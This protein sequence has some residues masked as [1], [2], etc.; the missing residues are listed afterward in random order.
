MPHHCAGVPNRKPLH[1]CSKG[2]DTLGRDESADQ[3]AK[4]GLGLF[5]RLHSSRLSSLGD[6]GTSPNQ[7]SRAGQR[8][9]SADRLNRSWIRSAQT[10][11]QWSRNQS[12]SRSRSFRPSEAADSP[13]RQPPAQGQRPRH[14]RPDR[15]AACGRPARAASARGYSRTSPAP[16]ASRQA[17]SGGQI[18]GDAG[19]DQ[20]TIEQRPG[21]IELNAQ[22]LRPPHPAS[23]L[24]PGNQEHHHQQH[25]QDRPGPSTRT[26][27]PQH[28]IKPR[29]DR[30]HHQVRKPPRPGP[31]GFRKLE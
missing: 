26:P 7:V 16:S 15:G 18:V 13:R 29:Q 27:R 5:G 10:T 11:P 25:H 9:S 1:Q 2:I 8:H 31:T 17:V 3:A 20:Q 23:C 14:G 21:R 24:E 4:R 12:Q 22:P 28:R 30:Q 19:Q 6:A